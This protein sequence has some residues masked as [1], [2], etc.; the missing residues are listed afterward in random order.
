MDADNDVG[1]S[2]SR[3][4]IQVLS[5]NRP[6]A[7]DR[8]IF[9]KIYCGIYRWCYRIMG[10]TIRKRVA[11]SPPPSRSDDGRDCGTAPSIRRQPRHRGTGLQ[12]YI[13][14][15]DRKWTAT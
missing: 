5:G 15:L 6:V 1:L 11:P 4:D 2:K 7:H 13:A 12:E 8:V 3:G 14:N 10:Q 9:R